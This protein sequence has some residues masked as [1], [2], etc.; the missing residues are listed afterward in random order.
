MIGFIRER[1]REAY[2]TETQRREI[3]MMMGAEM[4]YV[5]KPRN[6]K[7]FQQPPEFKREAQNKCPQKEPALPTL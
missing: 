1:R 4:K 6:P 2:G 3:H 7:D 5:Y